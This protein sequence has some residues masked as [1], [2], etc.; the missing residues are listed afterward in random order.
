MAEAEIVDTQVRSDLIAVVPPIDWERAAYIPFPKIDSAKNSSVL[1]VKP[2][3]RPSS[4]ADR[5]VIENHRDTAQH[6]CLR[7][8]A[9]NVG[10]GGPLPAG[11]R[12]SVLGLSEGRKRARQTL[13]L[14]AFLL[15]GEASLRRL[16]AGSHM[17]S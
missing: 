3:G 17:L 11:V 14:C 10:D 9:K 6:Y 8:S 5:P 2:R 7:E 15:I 13:S 12:P 1:S 4:E 16:P